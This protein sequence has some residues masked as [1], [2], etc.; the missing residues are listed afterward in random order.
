V[1]HYADQTSHYQLMMD[2]LDVAGDDGKGLFLA[3]AS[4]DE[5]RPVHGGY[6]NLDV[7][8][9]L[10]AFAD[11]T[12]QTTNPA[13]GQRLIDYRKS[14]V[15]TIRET[16]SIISKISG[17]NTVTDSAATA[18]TQVQKFLDA[19]KAAP[20]YDVP[21]FNEGYFRQALQ[22]L[23]AAPHTA[24]DVNNYLNQYVAQREQRAA[25]IDGHTKL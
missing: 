6:T 7:T 14:V 12:M 24:A 8:I 18:A 4:R 10:V 5:I 15:S 21:G 1:E 17:D 23:R 2:M 11:H 22:A 13:A 20:H 9:D 25:V 16:D 3:G 19:W